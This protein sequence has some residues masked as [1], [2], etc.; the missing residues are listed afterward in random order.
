ML[1]GVEDAQPGIGRIARQQ[2]HFHPRR[3]RRLALVQR[4]QLA[5]HREGD[6]RTQHVIFVLA[7][8]LGV[9][10]HAFGLEQRVA[11]FEVEQRAR[12]HGNGQQA[13]GVVAHGGQR[14]FKT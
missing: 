12:G 6:T 9:G 1:D 7:L 3:F 10:I 11:L 4:K 14:S 8:V 2:D 13:G 5:H